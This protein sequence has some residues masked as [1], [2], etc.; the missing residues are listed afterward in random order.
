MPF[1]APFNLGPF[2]VDSLG[3]ISPRRGDTAPGFI[4]CWRGR[5]VH[6]RLILGE[7]DGCRLTLRA[8]LGR[9]PSTALAHERD[10][11]M[12]G[13]AT[14]RALPRSLPEKW[15]LRLMPD[16]R[17]RLETDAAIELPIT[18]VVLVTAL[19]K[20]LLDLAPYLDLLD[21]IGVTPTPVWAD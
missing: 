15:V 2:E 7:T 4:F 17:L 6:A 5:S 9:I 10:E 1:D 8:G 21:E 11:R 16:H 20:F 14:L 18:V 3:H 19:S 12:R 13:F